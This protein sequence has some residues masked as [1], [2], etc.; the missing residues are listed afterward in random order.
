MKPYRKK[1]PYPVDKWKTKHGFENIRYRVIQV[2]DNPEDL[3]RFENEWITFFGTFTD[4]KLGG[5]NYTRGGQGWAG[6]AEE[7]IEKIREANSRDNTP[8]SKLTKAK[9]SEIRRRYTLGETTSDLAEEFGIT[10]SHLSSV[11]NNQVWRDP[12]YTFQRV[13]PEPMRDEDR[14]SYILS[15]EDA[16]KMRVRYQS[17]DLTY[18]EISEE[19]EVSK[20]LVIKV[21]NNHCYFDAEYTPGRPTTQRVRDALSRATKGVPKPPGHG[22][23]VAEAIRGSN[24]G[25]SKL[26]ESKVIEIRRLKKSGVPSKEL[27]QMFGVRYTQVNRICNGSRWGHIK[28][29]LE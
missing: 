28:E 5:L 24:H 13:Y 12:D 14:G 6:K 26:D 22:A 21:L 23:K 3:D 9:A 16:D 4:W 20:G 7:V 10:R 11:L 2:V 25:M 1:Q 8:W 29:G 18:E 17:S 15:R 27:A 19:F